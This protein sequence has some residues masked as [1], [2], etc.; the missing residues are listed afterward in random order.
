MKTNVTA[1][2]T[3][4]HVTVACD[5]TVEGN[6]AAADFAAFSAVVDAITA[7]GGDWSIEGPSYTGIL[8]G[9]IMTG[10]C[11]TAHMTAGAAIDAARAG[12]AADRAKH[13]AY[14]ARKAV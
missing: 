2:P 6:K 9:A 10:R 3:Y 11:Y 5:L 1:Y 4:I 13:E 7:A 14:L 8:N 12:A